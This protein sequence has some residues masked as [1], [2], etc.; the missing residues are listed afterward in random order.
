MSEH[1]YFITLG[2]VFGTIL[3]VFGMRYL[4]VGLQAKARLASEQAYRQLAETAAA[5]QVA[6]LAAL[7][8]IEQRLDDLGP[9]VMVVEKLLKDIG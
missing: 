8:R 5:N 6:A 1:I 3:L 4:S 7:S 2:L 9:R